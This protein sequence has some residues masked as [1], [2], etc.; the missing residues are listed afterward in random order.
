MT[1]DTNLLKSSINNKP[2]QNTRSANYA[3]GSQGVSAVQ[4]ESRSRTRGKANINNNEEYPYNQRIDYAL[5]PFKLAHNQKSSKFEFE[6]TEEFRKKI[7]HAYYGSSDKQKDLPVAFVLTSWREDD[8]SNQK[9]ASDTDEKDKK[10]EWP[11]C[12][13]ITVN[14]QKP[15]IIKRVKIVSNNRAGE[16]VT[17]YSGKDYP[18]DITYCLN[19]G[20]NSIT[21]VQTECA[22]SYRFAIQVIVRNNANRIVEAISTRH[23][24]I[25]KGKNSINRLLGSVA[26]EDENDEILM[27]QENVKLNLRCPISFVRIELPV[28]GINCQ[29]PD[30]FDLA[31]Y[32]ATNSNNLKWKCPH[33][34]KYAPP[35]ELLRD[36]FFEFLLK[37][38][39]RTARQIEFTDSSD[40]W[41]VSEAEDE[42]DYAED[43]DTDGDKNE[44][45]KVPPKEIQANVISLLSDDEDEEEPQNHTSQKRGNSVSNDTEERRKMARTL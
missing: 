15:P 19:N 9:K 25:D 22:C 37:K 18:C 3:T 34:N 43:D 32:L 12:V 2:G 17:S 41:V 42:D 45:S 28:K 6:N 13:N 14:N 10:C 8:S 33:C 21:L 11:Q 7:L 40:A 38:V 29:H 16:S 24:A 44:K 5:K 1:L 4:P 35:T 30:C 26:L 31:S 20:P 36:M 23:L 39:P 27:R